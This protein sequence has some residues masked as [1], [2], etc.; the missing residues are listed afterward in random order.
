MAEKKKIHLVFISSAILYVLIACFPFASPDPAVNIV[1]K[2]NFNFSK[3]K[4]K[5][6][7]NVCAI[8]MHEYFYTCVKYM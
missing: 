3:D 4:G 7:K 8:L 5:E 6:C 2:G 1:L